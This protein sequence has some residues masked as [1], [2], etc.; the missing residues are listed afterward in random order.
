MTRSARLEWWKPAVHEGRRPALLA[1][2]RILAGLRQWLAEHDFLEVDP[3]A[4]ALSPGNE[5]HLHGFATTLIGNDGQGQPMY[6][7]TSPEFAM[8]KLL[9]AGETR[10]ASFAHVWRNRERGPRHSPEFTMLEWYRVGE[11]YTVLMQDCMEFMQLAATAAGSGLFC[12]DGATCD[13]FAA[14]ERLSVAEAFSRYAGIDLLATLDAEGEP[15]TARLAAAV[16]AA[17]LRR[18]TDD[19]WSDLFS[20]V[21]SERVE[22]HLGQGRATI[23][24]RYPAAEAALA[25]RAPDDPRVSERFELYACGVELANGFGELTNPVEQRRRF[26]L[27]MAEKQRVYG[28]T[29]P[30]DEDF[31][32]ALALMPPASGIALGFDRL[33]MLATH[34]P[35]IDDVI[36]TPLP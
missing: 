20:R 29:Y 6:L 27:E 25:R 32:E 36:W 15:D 16:D 22:P 3:A 4:L 10:I 17:G 24:D 5:A 19:T 7:H 33:V 21:L 8:K 30:L 9:A 26:E 23:L 35:R 14:P 34:A 1:R 31:L 28:E 18:A 12:W 11:D 13:P 2:N